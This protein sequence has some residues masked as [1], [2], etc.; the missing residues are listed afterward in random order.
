[1]DKR[2]KESKITT[3]I[4]VVLLLAFG[5]S[6]INKV[7]VSSVNENRLYELNSD[8]SK[9]ALFLAKE[10]SE[11]EMRKWNVIQNVFNDD[12][13][14][15]FGEFSFRNTSGGTTKTIYDLV[16]NKELVFVP[17]LEPDQLNGTN[18]AKVMTYWNGMNSRYEKIKN[19][20]FAT[21]AI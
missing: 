8:C 11:T 15:C 12:K 10:K 18:D 17:S 5:A 6:Y 13:K 4:I 20:T 2:I 3:T 21:T 14:S 19:E 9:K 1:M 16:L 7:P